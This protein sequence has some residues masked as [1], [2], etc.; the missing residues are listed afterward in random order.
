M[1]KRLQKIN[2]HDNLICLRKKSPPKIHQRTSCICT[3]T[4]K[5]LLF[6]S[7]ELGPIVCVLKTQGDSFTLWDHFSW[8]TEKQH[9]RRANSSKGLKGDVGECK[10]TVDPNALHP[11]KLLEELFLGRL[12]QSLHSQLIFDSHATCIPDKIWAA[13]LLPPRAETGLFNF[14]FVWEHV[15]VRF[16]TERTP[17]HCVVLGGSRRS[18]RISCSRP[19]FCVLISKLIWQWG[20]ATIYVACILTCD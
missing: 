2:C 19:Q 7:L 15:R 18:I 14:S 11:F 5:P 8:Y 20:P 4:H 9:Q 16:R 13:R 1:W 6:P 10:W 12:H 3:K 17:P